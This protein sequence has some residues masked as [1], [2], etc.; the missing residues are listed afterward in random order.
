MA[1]YNS[2]VKKS[3]VYEKLAKFGNR[4][5]FLQSLSQEYVSVEDQLK[6]ATTQ[7]YST[8][9]NWI[10][11]SAD[12]QTDVPGRP[13]RGLPAGLRQ[14]VN[15]LLSIVQNGVYD[16]DTLPK[17]KA[18][19]ANILNVRNLGNLSQNASTAWA[20]SVFP[21]A[22]NVADLINTQI[23]F[24]KAWQKK[25]APL[26]SEEKPPEPTQTVQTPAATQKKKLNQISKEV[27]KS[28]V[29]KVDKL[30]DGPNRV[31]QLREVELGV[32]TLQNYFRRLQNSGNLN[33]YFARMDIVNALNKVYNTL[34]NNDFQT[35]VSLA[36]N[37]G[38]LPESPDSKI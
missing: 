10:K 12:R 17:L 18:A 26:M 27:S 8:I 33:D 28:L 20:N 35:V 37:S 7:L 1:K 36:P 5:D 23:N 19:V 2:L 31:N 29:N 22:N 25:N 15:T 3:E 13:E 9:Q 16:I 6:A 30:V 38:G 11:N 14:P 34:D 21:Q 32:K 4:S 24:L